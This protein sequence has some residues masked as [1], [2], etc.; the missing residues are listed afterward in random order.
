MLHPYVMAALFKKIWGEYVH[1]IIMSIAVHFQATSKLSSTVQ[2][3]KLELQP[4]DPNLDD[5]LP[6]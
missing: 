1:V 3:P 5:P 4:D 6:P 2:T